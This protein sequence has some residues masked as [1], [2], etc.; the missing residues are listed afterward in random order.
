MTRGGILTVGYDQQGTLLN[1]VIGIT[2]LERSKLTIFAH[3]KVITQIHGAGDNIVRP[4]SKVHVANR[5]LGK[6]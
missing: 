2:E 6:D 5:S 3:F 1:S 4:S